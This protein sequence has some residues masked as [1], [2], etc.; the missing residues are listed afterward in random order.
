MRRAQ[1]LLAALTLVGLLVSCRI[2]EEFDGSTHFVDM[3]PLALVIA[4]IGAA[5]FIWNR[6][7]K[8]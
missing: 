6:G 4:V 2:P 1:T 5:I 8:E 3:I 7:R